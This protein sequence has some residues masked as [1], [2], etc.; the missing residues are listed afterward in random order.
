MI[1]MDHKSGNR[2]CVFGLGWGDEGKGKIVDLLCQDH[3]IVVRF[4]GGA[5]AGH[6]V[7]VGDQTFAM[8]L[9]PS[10]I[11]HADNRA[12]I[13]PGVVVDPLTL[14]EEIES[15]RR[16]GIVFDGRLMISERAHLVLAYHKIEDQLS[17]G[18]ASEGVKIG[19][20]ARGIGPCYADKMR[21]KEAVR[22]ADLLCERDLAARVRGIVE[23]RKRAFSAIYGSDGGL[24]ADAILADIERAR[25][26][27]AGYVCDTTALL[28]DAVEEGASILFEGANGVLLD[29]D[30]GTY[31]FVTS[32][33][34]GPHGVAA[35]AGV[36]ATLLTRTVGVAKAYSTR[37]GAGP[38]VTE[39]TGETGDRIRTKGHEFGTTTGRPRRCGWF[40]AVAARYALRLT[41]CR[42]MALMHLDTLSG[43]DQVGVC[44]AY[45]IDGER[46]DRFPAECDR[47]SQA[48]PVFEMWPGWAEEVRGVQRFDD[49]PSQAQAYV[50]RLED[51][52]GVRISI[53]STG[54]ERTETVMRG[55]AVNTA[56]GK[57]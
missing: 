33:H 34:A 36:P 29:I 57:P 27:L 17:E 15:M 55:A 22:F 52:L 40:D 23:R 9:L 25:S 26:G 49:L 11:L 2:T 10:G 14:L 38:F 8:H 44:V 16:R 56:L 35:G 28:F 12:V 24:D 30:H 5:N 6:T 37:V 3:D 51:L 45:E 4:N 47:L 48:K 46:D 43:F 1:R 7:R 53:V 32:S 20:T 19:T 13:G 18:D 39:L 42:E 31:P 41:G 50:D 21:R 54:P